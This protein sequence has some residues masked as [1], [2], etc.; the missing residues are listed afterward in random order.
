MDFSW[1]GCIWLALRIVAINGT[2]GLI[3][4][5]TSPNK[6]MTGIKEWYDGLSK[7]PLSPPNYVFPI[8]WT[9]LYTMMAAAS[10]IVD[11][12]GGCLGG[13]MDQLVPPEVRSELQQLFAGQLV[14]NFMWSPLF[15]RLRRADYSLMDMLLL[16]G[17]VAYTTYRYSEYSTVAAR[18]MYPYIAWLAFAVHLNVYVLVFNSTVA[19]KQHFD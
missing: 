19:G 8:A 6:K 9:A 16:L 4:S 17:T 2:G 13:T 11:N 10:Y 5:F 3:A 7:S 14:L 12:N 15:F 18:L 1:D